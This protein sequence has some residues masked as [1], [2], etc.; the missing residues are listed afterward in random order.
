MHSID[1]H[2]RHPQIL[3]MDFL[4]IELDEEWPFTGEGRER[5]GVEWRNREGWDVVSLSLVVNFVPD[6]KNRGMLGR[7]LSVMIYFHH[8]LHRIGRM[9]VLAHS[10]LRPG[11]LL[12]LV[13]RHLAITHT[14]QALIWINVAS[15]SV[16]LQFPLYDTRPS[17]AAN[18]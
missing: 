3:E 14:S 13:V 7:L 10:L 1:L 5:K 6:I 17:H 16:R 18:G 8:P 9:L 2:S 15:L 11:G 12:F 4:D